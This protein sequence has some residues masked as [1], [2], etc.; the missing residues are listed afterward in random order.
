MDKAEK[1]CQRPPGSRTGRQY[2]HWHQHAHLWATKSRFQQLP[3]KAIPESPD[4]P[5][6]GPAWPTLVA[7][8]SPEPQ[9]SITFIHPIMLQILINTPAPQP[10]NLHLDKPKQINT[11][12]AMVDTVL[13]PKDTENAPPIPFKTN[14]QGPLYETKIQIVYALALAMLPLTNTLKDSTSPENWPY[15]NNFHQKFPNMRPLPASMSTLAPQ[16]TTSL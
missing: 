8:A 15:T 7:R 9:L 2:N 14:A 11:P 12:A 16:I 1:F 13:L 4:P 3:Q 6:G 10:A 5:Q